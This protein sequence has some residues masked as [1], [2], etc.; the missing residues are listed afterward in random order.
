[1]FPFRMLRM[2]QC[3]R[4]NFCSII[5]F[6]VSTGFGL[7]MARS[8]KPFHQQFQFVRKGESHVFE[9]FEVCL[10][11]SSFGVY[12]LPGNG[13]Q[14][15]SADYPVGRN[16]PSRRISRRAGHCDRHPRVG[17]SQAGSQEEAEFAV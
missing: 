7:E 15:G 5:V 12:C 14:E 8:S 11:G 9:K 1:M 6:M 2:T 10:S 17:G 13:V 16:Q 4:F 3:C